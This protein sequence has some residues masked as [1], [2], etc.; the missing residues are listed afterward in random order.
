MRNIEF[1]IEI[2]YINMLKRVLIFSFLIVILIINFVVINSTY[3]GISYA[4]EDEIAYMDPPTIY[5]YDDNGI[6]K[7]S[8]GT[9][10]FSNLL[11]TYQC[12]V[13]DC[14]VYDN[15]DKFLVIYDGTYNLY[16]YTTKES[17][18]LNIVESSIEDIKYLNK[19]LLYI[20]KD[21]KY[22]L[23]DSVE[24]KYISSY[25]YDGIYN[26]EGA[27]QYTSKYNQELDTYNDAQLESHYKHC[28][29][30]ESN[31]FYCSEHMDGSITNEEVDA[32]LD[33]VLSQYPDLDNKR[34]FLI[35][36]AIETVG[37]PYLWGG[38]HLSLDNTLY[39]ANAAWGLEVVYLSNGFRNQVAG[40]Y[41]PSGLDCA[42]FVRWA[43]YIASGVDLYVDRVNV[44]SGNNTDVTLINRE[45]L[46]PGDIIL[47]QDH[48]VIYLYK[49]AEGNDISV[50]A[51]YDNLKV[52]I[53]NYKKGNT[54]YRLNKWM[55]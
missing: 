1:E 25:I 12:T 17:R 20:K 3:D 10:G 29:K 14:K 6:L 27:F 35:K 48:V 22:A 30:L 38:G 32:Q 53:S 37:L 15:N 54:Y 52:E 42:G 55:Q 13:V 47:D 18:E 39:I 46:L 23:F 51:S 31:E 36:S 26:N 11:D 9:I 33:I 43:Y 21:N 4:K 5:I 8:T 49:D 45:D 7:I 44:I 34:I 28:S 41:Y 50:H 24:N 40:N 19:K 2:P 16:N